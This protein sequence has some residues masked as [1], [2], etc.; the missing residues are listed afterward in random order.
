M[1][2]YGMDPIV[3][4]NGEIEAHIRARGAELVSLQ[5]NG[6]GEVLWKPD[7]RYWNATSPILFPIIGRAPGG[8]VRVGGIEH[9]MPPHGFAAASDFSIVSRDRESC[10][11][12][13]TENEQTLSAY[14]FRFRLQLAY[15][16]SGSAIAC[17]AT[18]INTGTVRL[19]ASV[20]FHP[21]FRWP[22]HDGADKVGHE[23]VF[24]EDEW[25]DYRLVRD[26]ALAPETHRLPLEQHCLTLREDLFETSALVMTAYRS[27][28]IR[29]RSR[30]GGPEIVVV[31]ENLPQLGLWM[32]PGGDFICIEPWRGHATPQGFAGELIERP[33]AFVLDPGGAS[34]STMSISVH[35]AASGA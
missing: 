22:L 14:P 26:G 20:G 17:S 10:V 1:D 18:V 2:G 6:F 25:L 13:L 8:T 33:A 35:G 11:L 34:V 3:L 27:R 12:S 32:R 16:L 24:A 23:I 28:A 5:H 4:G 21:G 29:Y 9:Q 15:R 7:A 31:R 19:P 30:S